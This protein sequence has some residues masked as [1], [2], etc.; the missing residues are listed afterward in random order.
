[1]WRHTAA[2]RTTHDGPCSRPDT[3]T[4]QYNVTFLEDYSL[5]Y[6]FSRL[7]L[8][9]PRDLVLTTTV[10]KFLFADVRATCL[11]SPHYVTVSRLQ[12]LP[13]AHCPRT[14]SIHMSLERPTAAAEAEKYVFHAVVSASVQS[15]AV[16]NRKVLLCRESNP[17]RRFGVRSACCALFS[18]LSEDEDAVPS[19]RRLPSTGLH[20]VISQKTEHSNRCKNLKFKAGSIN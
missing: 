19:K 17:Y 8:H 16:E 2:S 13:S 12:F 10:Y 1:M 15:D 14:P 11:A 20:C 9:L 5:H 18:C 7:R 4:P 6:C 3:C